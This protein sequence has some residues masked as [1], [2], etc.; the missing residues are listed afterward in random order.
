MDEHISRILKMLEEQ[1][2]SAS[3]AETLISAL[4]ADARVNP[5]PPPPPPGAHHFPPPGS[6]PPP[7]G[8]GGRPENKSESG[9]QSE[10]SNNA[11]NFDFSW[12]QKK[13]F[14]FDLSSLGKQISDAVKKIDPEKLV[15]EARS[16]MN[17][18]S[19]HW[20]DRMRGWSR[21]LEGEDG[22]P[23]NTLGQPTSRTTENLIFEMMP[24]ATVSIENNYGSISV[25]GGSE[26][27]SIEIEKEGW[28]S[29]E[30][31][32][33]EHLKE[34]KVEAMSHQMPGVGATRLE[35]RV[36]AP[37][38]WRDGYANLRLRV[39]EGVT[40]RVETVFGELRVENVSGSVD[41]HTVTGAVSLENLGG[42]VR[43]EG[44]SG[45]MRAIKIGG[46]LHLA[47]KSGDIYVEGLSQGGDVTGVS[48]DVQIRNVEGA[49]LEAKS[50]SGDVFVE[51]AG[52]QSPVD[53]TVE[54]VSGDVRI[55]NS[56]GNIVLKT[57]SGNAEGETLQAATFQG[58][59]VSG[60][61]QVELTA[62]FTGT[63]TTNTVSGDV[64][65]RMPESS[66]FR[67]TLGTQSGDLECDLAAHE[68]N[69]TNTLFTGTVGSGDGT[70]TIQTRSGDVHLKKGA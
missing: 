9:S 10:G 34:L 50:V 70:I 41:V 6:P 29:T 18:G 45:E 31:A 47:A 44:I 4:R 42:E 11:K 2:I 30:E 25:I 46:L 3:E 60:D 1:K 64:E 61:V 28:D 13:S 22:R 57:V 69:H 17:R 32:A 15:K 33:A 14:P 58:Q 56:S 37:E 59:T 16:G 43:A 20:Q 24:N 66:S 68:T 12:G 35:V 7:P 52:Q 19:K 21:F 36:T 8:S 5:T 38:D 53:V 23:E 26:A 51:G 48:G 40:L 65:I 39:P 67:F 55:A 54:S 49:K 27:V 62:G 63:L